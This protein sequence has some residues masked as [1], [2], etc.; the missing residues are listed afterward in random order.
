MRRVLQHSLFLVIF[1]GT[2]AFAQQGQQQV[3]PTPNAPTPLL[4]G[5]NQTACLVA[6]DTQVMNCRNSCVVPAT[7]ANPAVNAPCVLSCSTQ[8]L[9]CK[10]ACNR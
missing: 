8:S 10:Q 1:S 4:L 5:P 6:C 3:Q 7:A 2:V 9:V